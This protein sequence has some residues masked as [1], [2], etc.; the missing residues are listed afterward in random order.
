MFAHILPVQCFYVASFGTFESWTM[1]ER[2]RRVKSKKSVQ[3]N[4]TS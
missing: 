2:K 4:E 3:I 1:Q